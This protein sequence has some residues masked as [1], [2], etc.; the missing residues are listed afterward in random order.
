M[1]NN[2]PMLN[3][4]PDSFCGTLADFGQFLENDAKGCFSSMYILPSLYQTDLDRGFSVKSYDLETSLAT[5]EDLERIKK[6]GIDLALD[7][8]LN[9]SS[10]LS[11]QFKD[12]LEKGKESKYY[13]FF[14]DWD[15]F[16]QDV[17]N[18]D[19]KISQMLFRKPGLP[20][21]QVACKD[22]T[23]IKFWNTFY[24]EVT[25]EGLYL[26]QMDLNINSPLVMDFYK[27][28]L[29]KLF[30]YGAS[31]IRLD[32]FAYAS[33]IPGRK[34][35]LNEPE[36][37]DLLN[38]IK[39]FSEGLNLELLPEIHASYKE[40]TYETISRKGFLAYDFFLPGLI[41]QAFETQDP[42][43]LCSWANE[44]IDKKI[45][46]INML[47]CH[48]GIPLLDLKGML[49]DEEISSLIKVIVNRGGLIKNL[50]GRTDIYYQ[51]NATYY[52]ALGEDDRKLLFS[53]V[54]QLFFPGKPQIW[55]LD[56]FAGKNNYEA[57]QFGHKEINRT[58]LTKDFIKEA[59]KKPI[60]QN[61]LKLL[62][63]R[64]TCK[65]F[66][67]DS[68]CQIKTNGSVILISWTDDNETALLTADLKSCEFKVEHNGKIVFLQSQIP[69]QVIPRN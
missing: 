43:H 28:T 14:I 41:L 9:H 20:F 35:F 62:R 5:I 10:V 17:E 53:R 22:G 59:L 63:F 26:G 25:K 52:S 23:K 3:A 64:N 65:A 54:L 29:K 27:E 1:N 47:G 30:D 32:A 44:L 51:V 49:S 57:A 19:E 34:N 38:K 12:V 15:K 4:Y 69:V 36:T 66:G 24:Q 56:L 61:Q 6:L 2:G 8:I 11:M 68:R 21:L 50:H 48:D 45:R 37:W 60:V 40:K 39:G 67:F 31:I 16:W 42:R 18:K 33:K 7:L 58:N 13:D 55:Y 46:T